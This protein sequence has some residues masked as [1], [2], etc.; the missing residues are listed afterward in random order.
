MTQKG[1]DKTIENVASITFTDPEIARRAITSPEEGERILKRAKT[2][3][4]QQFAGYALAGIFAAHAYLVSN[5]VYGIFQDT[6]TA[7]DEAHEISMT[8][9]ERDLFVD[10][11]YEQL[12]E[13][14]EDP[15]IVN[16]IFL[17]LLAAAPGLYAE[18]LKT[19]RGYQRQDIRDLAQIRQSDKEVAA[20]EALRESMERSND[21][22][23]LTPQSIEIG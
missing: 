6:F 4:R 11:R 1:Y 21:N 10:R 16:I 17:A 14:R 9:E 3:R 23:K 8:E 12:Q 18:F 20:M 2:L 22:E 15:S 5:G 7:L 19:K 13:E